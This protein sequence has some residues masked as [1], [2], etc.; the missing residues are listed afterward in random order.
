MRYRTAAFLILLFGTPAAAAAQTYTATAD[1][2]FFGD[3]TE[4]ANPFRT[5]ETVLGVS[6]RVFLDVALNDAVTIRGGVF[7]LGRFG[8]HEFMEQGEPMVAL[9]ISRG[10]SRFIFGSLE[11]VTSRH[12]VAGPDLETLH[13]LLPPLQRETLSF[14]RG[15]EMGLQWLAAGQT[16][17]HDTWINWQ[18]LNTA[19]HRERFDA[20]YRA[21]VR[22]HPGLRLQGQWHVVHEGGQQFA[23]GPVSD[24]QGI[25]LGLEWSRTAGQTRLTF[26]SH[27]VATRDVPDREQP[28][29]TEAGIGVFAR[30]AVERNFWRAHVLVWRSRDARKTEGD[31]NYL[32]LLGDGTLFRKVRDYGELGLTRH[33]RPAPGVH[34][35][36]AGRLHR[37]ESAYEYSYR[38]VARV[39]LRHRF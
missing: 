7:G 10:A 4:F 21:G 2:L 33:F 20:G 19:T 34:L 35:F 23:S 14:T 15:Q 16:F 11:T 9:E 27:A 5:G 13:G 17:E 26:D 12:D 39:R 22:L 36:V 29:L 31:A 37:V 28:A 38:I 25:A 6:G 18:R 1:L 24:S 3:N 8:S 32:A 30:S